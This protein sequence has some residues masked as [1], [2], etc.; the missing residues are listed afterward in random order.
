MSFEFSEVQRKRPLTLQLTTMIDVFTLIIIFLMMST[1]LSNV[2]IIIPSGMKQA[3]SVS[4]EAMETAPQ[5]VIDKDKVLFPTLK[6]EFPLR[7][8]LDQNPAEL[9]TLKT[10]VTEYI[11]NAAN[12]SKNSVVNI[13]VVAD[14]AT[15]YKIVF[16]VVK[17]LRQSGF[18]SVLFIAEGEAPPKAEGVKGQ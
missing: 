11:K 13:N 7:F 17:V 14:A 8:F 3:K 10:L 5:V 18:Q 2:S 4:K 16:N 12:D 6:Q 15:P 1:V 9:A